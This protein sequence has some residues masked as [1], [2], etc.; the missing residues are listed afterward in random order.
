MFSFCKSTCGLKTNRPFRNP[1]PVQ[2]AVTSLAHRI[3]CYYRVPH[4]LFP[5]PRMCAHPH[6]QQHFPMIWILAQT[7]PQRGPSF[8]TRPENAILGPLDHGILVGLIACY[9]RL[10][11]GSPRISKSKRWNCEC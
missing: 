10:V 7:K 11:N 8:T 2:A 6:P 1:L 3:H 5:Q 9:G 4:E